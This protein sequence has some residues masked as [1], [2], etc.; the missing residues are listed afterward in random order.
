MTRFDELLAVLARANVDFILVGGVAAAAHGSPRTTQDIDI[1]YC[2][3]PGNPDKLVQALAPYDPYL[4]GSPPGLPFALDK[5]T[6][7]AGLNFTLTTSLGWIDL[8]GEIIGGGG[9]DDLLPH[10][11]I[12]E[13]FGQK[14]RVLD[15]ETLIATKRAV[16][17]PRIL[18]PWLNCNCFRSGSQDH[19]VS[20][21]AY[22][23]PV[24]NPPFAKVGPTRSRRSALGR[25][26]QTLEK[27]RTLPKL[28]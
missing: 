3:K 7:K 19:R 22:Q 4:R 27:A 21:T 9:Y 2:R 6:L 11:V 17:R 26:V 25:P 14:C 28:P 13:L 15:L 10:S 20:N 16:G 24:A 12:L 1:V 23:W 5:E 18:K 8:L